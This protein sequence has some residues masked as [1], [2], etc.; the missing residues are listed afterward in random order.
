[1]RA[2]TGCGS[3]RD[4]EDSDGEGDEEGTR[5]D[6][7]DSLGFCSR[8]VSTAKERVGNTLVTA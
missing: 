2:Q 6:H 3:C 1:M 4:G 8:D 5:C 7:I